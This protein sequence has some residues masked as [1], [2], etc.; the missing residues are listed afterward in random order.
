MNPDGAI[1]ILT[2]LGV[3]AAFILI[4]AVIEILIIN[5]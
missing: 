4:C 5:D 1:M 3:I 2:M